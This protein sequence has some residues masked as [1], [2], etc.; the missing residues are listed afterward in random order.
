MAASI[1]AK[2]GSRRA[3]SAG[4]ASPRRLPSAASSAS[5][6]WCAAVPSLV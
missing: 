4:N 5:S 3:N 2:R 6:C 1:V